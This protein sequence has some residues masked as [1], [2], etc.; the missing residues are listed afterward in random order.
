MA[1]KDDF[2]A[3]EWNTISDA[4]VLAGFMVVTASKGGTIRETFSMSKSWVEAR[5]HHGESELLDAVVAEKPKVDRHEMPSSVELREKAL[6]Q[7]SEAKRLISEKAP[8]DLDA[9]RNFVKGLAQ[10]VAEAHKEHGE[11][12]SEGESEVLGQIESALNG[13]ESGSAPE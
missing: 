6:A 7:L 1:T 9:Y 4:P 2:S 10:N 8:A 12:V 3:E 13:A 5:Q 11:Q